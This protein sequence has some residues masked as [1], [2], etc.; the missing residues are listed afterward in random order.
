MAMQ[1]R[2]DG[3][4]TLT[5][6]MRGEERTDR[7]I[8]ADQF[9][10]EATETTEGRQAGPSGGVV[11]PWSGGPTHWPAPSGSVAATERL[12]I[13]GW[14]ALRRCGARM[15][16]ASGRLPTAE[17]Q[18][19]AP[20]TELGPLGERIGYRTCT[21]RRTAGC[22]AHLPFVGVWGQELAPSGGVGASAPTN[23]PTAAARGTSPVGGRSRPPTGEHQPSAPHADWAPSGSASA[24]GRVR[25]PDDWQ[26]PPPPFRGRGDAIPRRGV[27]G[28]RPAPAKRAPG[29]S[30]HRPLPGCGGT[31]PHERPVER[32]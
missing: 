32:T 9:T 4:A 24:A 21:D 13:A 15:R 17:H 11:R 18:P 25:M 3:S 1:V 5:M 16:A 20:H 27:R 6:T 26:C 30:E 8:A 7:P 2:R 29:V 19:S 14:L 12:R 10:T 22:A 31:R 28:R 23:W